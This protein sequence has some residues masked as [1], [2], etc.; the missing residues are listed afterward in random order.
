[1]SKN[2]E[3]ERELMID[4]RGLSKTYRIGQIGGATLRQEIRDRREMRRAKKA[5]IPIDDTEKS[6]LEGKKLYALRGIDLQIY[7]GE[8]VGIIG[9]NGAGKSTLLKLIC[10]ITAPTAG[11]IDLYGR[12]TSMLEVG[13]GFD[14]ELTG[15]ENVY[16]NG[17]ILGMNRAE[18][19]AKMDDIVA[20]A[21]MEDFI[22]TPVKR[23]SS[24]MYIK[25]GFSV[26]M[27]LESDIM[28]MDEVL[29]V[30]DQAFQ[31]KCI[32]AMRQAAGEDGKTVL[33]V[34]HNMNQIR[35]LCDRCIVMDGGK[36]AFI[37]DTE[38]AIAIYLDQ[39]RREVTQFDYR[40][41][42]RPFWLD[43]TRLRVLSAAFPDRDQAIF[44]R[45]EQPRVRMELECTG[46]IDGVCLRIEIRDATDRRIGTSVLYD[47]FDARAGEHRLLET[48]YDIS[49]LTDGLYN[50]V[51]TFFERSALGAN[52]NLDNVPGL[53]FSVRVAEAPG[54]VHWDQK[55]WGF[56]QFPDGIV[57]ENRLLP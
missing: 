16:L 9:K 38:E 40:D 55:E 11:S 2:S 23:Y 30:G 35:R 15:R 12:L 44:R 28:I 5:G 39:A 21:G 48:A 46:D 19:D 29:A 50:T 7:R 4:I 31:N 26:A 22:D 42:P 17:S 33:Y 27:H 37:G 56:V 47:L 32:D 8:T 43:D 14:G 36:I 10:R 53:S 57:T 52:H 1:M 18:I 25:L 34:S 3:N 45:D 6:R 51:Y 41:Y 13:T 24:G 49:A 20:F 54:E